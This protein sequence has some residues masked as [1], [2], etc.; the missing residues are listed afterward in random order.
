MNSWDFDR[1]TYRRSYTLS[2][3]I[4]K[5]IRCTILGL[6]SVISVD[7][8]ALQL[9]SH[10]F[11][12]PSVKCRWCSGSLDALLRVNRHLELA[13]ILA[14]SWPCHS[15]LLPA[16]A[17]CVEMNTVFP[18]NPARF[19]TPQQRV[20]SRGATATPAPAQ[21]PITA[22]D[23][24]RKLTYVPGPFRDSQLS[25]HVSRLVHRPIPEQPDGAR[26]QMRHR[27]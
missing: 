9:L 3:T 6:C 19:A 11:R 13:L 23:Y 25:A 16:F 12:C 22:D 24:E 14:P 10:L 8:R 26:P 27:L 18:T 17:D 7:C 21:R 4:M 2:R 20:P 15:L 5:T 1:T